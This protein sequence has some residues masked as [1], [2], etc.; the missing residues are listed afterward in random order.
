[1]STSR[2]K[3]KKDKEVKE[4]MTRYLLEKLKAE[5]LRP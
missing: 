2:H 1:M 5:Q 3:S 4:K